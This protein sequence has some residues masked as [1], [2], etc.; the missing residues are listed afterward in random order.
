MSATR[1]RCYNAAETLR[2]I[3]DAQTK[4]EDK[5]FSGNEGSDDM[6]EVSDT[7]SNGRSGGGSVI[8]DRSDPV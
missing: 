4:G 3:V 1:R 8:S 5:D 6:C 2:I 7:D